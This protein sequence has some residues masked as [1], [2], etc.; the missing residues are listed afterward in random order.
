MDIFSNYPIFNTD[1]DPDG[2]TGKQLHSATENLKMGKDSM[3][4]DLANLHHNL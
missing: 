2:R 4:E 3:T 1:L